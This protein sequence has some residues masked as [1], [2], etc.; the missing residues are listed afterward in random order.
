MPKRRPTINDHRNPNATRKGRRTRGPAA[1]HIVEEFVVE[2]LGARGDGLL[3]SEG[4]RISV[5]GALPGERVRAALPIAPGGD[6]RS[7]RRERVAERPE[8]LSPSP[9]RAVPSCSHFGTCGGCTIQHVRDD[10][11]ATW[12]RNLIASSLERA[13]L[14]VAEGIAPLVRSA[15]GSRR[16]AEFVVRRG[17]SGQETL[18]YHRRGSHDLVPLTECPVLYPALWDAAQALK[19]KIM[20]LLQPGLRADLQLTLGLGGLDVVLGPV[21]A[22]T[23]EGR[24]ALADLAAACDLARLTVYEDVAG[25]P[26]TVLE[27]RSARIALDW[28]GG[29]KPGPA[30]HPPAG[31]F[32]QA[33]DVGQSALIS[34]VMAA[35][36]AALAGSPPTVTPSDAG[37]ERLAAHGVRF[38]DLFAGCGTF[39]LPLA[40]LAPVFAVEG[41]VEA[42][43]ALRAAAHAQALP[44]S[45]ELADLDR[46]PIPAD[47][48]AGLA[49][50]VF[51]PPRAGAEA[52]ARELA[53]AQLGTVIAVSCNPQTFARDARILA[54]GG[55]RLLKVTPIDQFLW[56]GHLEVVGVFAR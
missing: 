27:R 50:V 26:P 9:D 32:L 44:V 35:A 11:Y 4:G 18:G 40:T 53:R 36:R 37:V 42:V 28:E 15:P 24:E 52:Q 20:P 45:V 48:L 29:P 5:P 7:V 34:V 51:D 1:T 16:R 31:G 56:T 55:W 41:Q 38:A 23:L 14:T 12:K 39:S 49:A 46:A 30:L 47:R 13:G 54:D 33:T 21:A 25:R 6:G 2:A 17:R 10:V 3:R 19:P 43:A 8:I 22:L